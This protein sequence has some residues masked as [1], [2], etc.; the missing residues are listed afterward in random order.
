MSSGDGKDKKPAEP[1]PEEEEAEEDEEG[2]ET[3]EEEEDPALT[4]ADLGDQDQQPGDARPVAKPPIPGQRRI[5]HEAAH[6]PRG[7]RGEAS[8]GSRGPRGSRSLKDHTR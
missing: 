5:R 2:E 1:P 4:A 8:A 6:P 7:D 3:E